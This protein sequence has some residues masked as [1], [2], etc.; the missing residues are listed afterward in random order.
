[1]ACGAGFSFMP[2]YWQNI[3]IT[4]AAL[5]M[6][7]LR[8][9]HYLR[10]ASCFPALR[11]LG[12]LLI[13]SSLPVTPVNGWQPGI[14]PQMNHKL[15]AKWLF[16][17]KHCVVAQGAESS[18]RT[19]LSHIYHFFSRCR[20]PSLTLGQCDGI[21]SNFPSVTKAVSGT[22]HRWMG[23]GGCWDWKVR[24]K[25]ASV[26][27]RLHVITADQS[28]ISIWPWSSALCEWQYGETDAI[29]RASH[30]DNVTPLQRAKLSCLPGDFAQRWNDQNSPDKE[31]YNYCSAP[32]NSSQRKRNEKF[33][34]FF[35]EWLTVNNANRPPWPFA[36]FLFSSAYKFIH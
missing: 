5:H 24:L 27:F 23:T 28:P 29:F 6:G 32:T 13:E 7:I 21:P 2:W 3:I 16:S 12:N 9:R 26:P 19:K 11:S 14:I 22:I 33:S 31:P 10:R 36:T 30:S 18:P 4:H 8:L 17:I 1:M 25:M 35:A 34:L 15:T 20:S